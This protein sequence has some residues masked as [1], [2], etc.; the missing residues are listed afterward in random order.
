MQSYLDAAQELSELDDTDP[1]LDDA[2][3]LAAEKAAA[4]SSQP[5]T[6]AMLDEVNAISNDKNLTDPAIDLDNDRTDEVAEEA[7][8][9]QDGP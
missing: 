8:E 3:E 6:E 4:A 2:V 1:D 9:I 7:R 5:V